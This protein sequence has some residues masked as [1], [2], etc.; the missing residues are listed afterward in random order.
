MNTRK[1]ITIE[2]YKIKKNKTDN[3]EEHFVDL[4]LP[5]GLKWSKTNLGAETET[6]YGN[7]YMWGS[8]KP[9]TAD[10]CKWTNAPFNGG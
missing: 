6:D 8:T 10:E 5:S 7:Y 9:N 4:G 2:M 1:K 3:I